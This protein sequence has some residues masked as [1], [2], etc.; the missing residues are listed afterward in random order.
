MYR[1][2]RGEVVAPWRGIYLMRE[3]VPGED[4]SPSAR[5]HQARYHW[6]K[7]L[8]E[9]RI[10]DVACG[11]GYGSL[12]LAQEMDALVVGA[13]IIRGDG[14]VWHPPASFL[15]CDGHR[16][17]F[18]HASFDGIVS[19]ETIEHLQD[20]GLFLSDVKRVLQE[21]GVFVL[22]TPNA[23]T[24]KPLNGIPRNPYHRH[25]YDAEELREVLSGYFHDIELYGQRVAD[26]YGFAPYW[27]EISVQNT[28]GRSWRRSV[29]WKLLLRTPRTFRER[30]SQ[31]IWSRSFY[32]SRKDFN[33]DSDLS[34]RSHVIVAVCRRKTGKSG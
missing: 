29:I 21:S 13:D 23:L 16:L 26:R 34:P 27:Q 31:A 8:L 14:A 4:E 11:H 7:P 33:F 1:C 2:D 6:V 15:L 19:F 17:P 32:P 3:R 12:V 25:E 20:A 28:Y 24:T 18:R 10:L 9:G 22:S 30:A 5:E